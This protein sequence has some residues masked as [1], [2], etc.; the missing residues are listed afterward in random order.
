MGC[1]IA[2]GHSETPACRQ[3]T[4]DREKPR[5]TEKKSLTYMKEY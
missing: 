3:E 4:P 2:L 5:N 1:H